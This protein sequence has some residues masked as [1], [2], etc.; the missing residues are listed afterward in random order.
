MVARSSHWVL[1]QGNMTSRKSN[2]NSIETQNMSYLPESDWDSRFS[3]PATAFG[4][5][6]PVRATLS[7]LSDRDTCGSADV[8]RRLARAAAYP[9]AL[10]LSRFSRAHA[11]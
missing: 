1:D 8:R 2:I 9:G 10:A 4:R 7:V 5:P 6:V 11:R 3:R